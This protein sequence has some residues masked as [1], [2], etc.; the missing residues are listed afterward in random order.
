MTDIAAT[1]KSLGFRPATEIGVTVVEDDPNASTVHVIG[2]CPVKGCKNR[3]RNTFVGRIVRDRH[4]VHTTWG[5][6]AT[7]GYG[8]IFPAV[9]RHPARPS[10]YAA[11]PYFNRTD[12]ERCYSQT[13]VDLMRQHGWVCDDHDQFMK[14]QAVKGIVN[15]EK[16][17]NARC[18]SATG[19]NCECV[20]GGELHGASF[21]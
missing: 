14:V 16:P 18:K 8:T 17:C 1:L 10:T 19:P 2:K 13:F 15:H 3:K 21:D 6:P 4:G 5:M 9:D 11:D 7:G 20:C 12:V